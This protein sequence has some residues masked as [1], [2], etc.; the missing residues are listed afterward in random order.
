ME[1]ESGTIMQLFNQLGQEEYRLIGIVTLS[2][3]VLS[4]LYVLFRKQK[5][6]QIIAENKVQMFQKTFD[7]SQDPT[8]ILSDK[9]NVLYAN[10]TMVTLFKLKRNFLHQELPAMPQIKIK[11]TWL[12][13]DQ[14]I[15]DNDKA[16][17]EHTLSFF[18]V[19]LRFEYEE[20]IPINLHLQKMYLH[21]KETEFSTIVSIQDLRKEQD[22]IEG[23][24]LHPVTNMP[25]EIQALHDVPILYSKI[26]L[27]NSKVALVLLHLDNL[28]MLRAIVG[29][30]QANKILIKF[31]DY[32]NSME[33]SLDVSAYHTFGNNFLLTISNINSSLGV[34]SLV[35]EI[36]EQVA[37]LYKMN[38]VRLHLTMSVG[39]SI[40]PDSGTSRNLLDN[41]YKALY[42]AEKSGEGR[43]HIYIPDDTKVDY[44]AFSL[45]N[46][47]YSALK[48]NEF[49]VY[50]QPVF[51]AKT[52]EI[53]SAEALV[54]W[55][56]PEHGIITPDVFIPLMEKTGFIIELDH[57]V[58]DE[59]LKQQKRWELF[60]F[61]QIVVSINV[62]SIEIKTEEFIENV[63]KQLMHYKVQPELIRFEITESSAL[64]NES[65]TQQYFSKLKA[66]G[67]GIT[68]DDFGTG[69]NSFSYLQQFPGELLKI[70][71]KLVDS[72]V[73]N[74][75]NQRIVKAMIELGHT[76]EMKVVVEGIE[77]QRMS[78]LI[79]SYGCDY[80]QGYYFSKPVPVFEFQKL[81]YQEKE[82][83]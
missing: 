30:E 33:T 19:Y 37:L 45:H 28:N 66:L 49:E 13:L 17:K 65:N 50:Y 70:D 57:F 15:H 71:R 58:L 5:R 8:L 72:I 83:V 2:I 6:Q 1:I 26:H 12:P 7:M 25:T 32:L 47:M 56:H 74:Q 38:E 27:E 82:G 23:Q 77:N 34:I 53:V 42:E 18:K 79:V 68:L 67:V 44:D 29:Y 41:A 80:L 4:Y 78:D 3:L 81:L 48:N 52:K 40:Y 76:L 35:E 75:E 11:E 55:V 10:R 63:E 46:E 43:V 69:Y 59:V 16:F 54:R 62:G 20:A 39:I 14:V 51:D 22:Y 64:S 31:T 9:N 21:E 60:Q 73:S 36:Q 61:K 24:H